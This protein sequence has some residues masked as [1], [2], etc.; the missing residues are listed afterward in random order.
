MPSISAPALFNACM[1]GDTAAVDRL[2]PAGGTRLNLSGS[3]FQYPNDNH[4]TPLM[5]AAAKG[6]TAIVRMLLERARNTT[7]DHVDPRGMTPLSMAALFH[8]AEILRLLAER[9]ANV[10]IVNTARQ[11]INKERSTP[12]HFALDSM[13]HHST[14]REP[15]HDGVRLVATVRALLRLGAGTLPRAP[16]PPSVPLLSRPAANPF[17]FLK[18]NFPA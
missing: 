18:H 5:V 12:L 4:E 6:Y 11:T 13:H 17:H 9:G 10:N 1:A 7:V 15:D 3:A 14:P 2:L 8:H 16:R